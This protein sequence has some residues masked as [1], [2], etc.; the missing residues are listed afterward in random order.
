MTI[1][2][3]PDGYRATVKIN[4]KNF[5]ADLRAPGELKIPELI[6]CRS[7]CGRVSKYDRGNPAYTA[8]PEAV[9]LETLKKHL[10]LFAMT[11]P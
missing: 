6:I 1:Q 2:N 4:G 5:V 10:F 3:L 8:Y 11:K 7:K 9:N